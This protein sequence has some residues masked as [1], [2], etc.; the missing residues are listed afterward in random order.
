M[1]VIQR[2]I[3]GLP[4]VR[5]EVIRQEGSSPR[6]LH[7]HLEAGKARRD[8]SGVVQG[9]REGNPMIVVS[10]LEP[11]QQHVQLTVHTVY[12]GDEEV[13]AQRLRALLA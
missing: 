3:D 11:G 9:L 1:A 8:A 10:P 4:G 7:V 5:T 12:E 13:I 6:V 2:V